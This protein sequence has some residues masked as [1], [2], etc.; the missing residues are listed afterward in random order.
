[1]VTKPEKNS[2]AWAISGNKMGTYMG[3]G[4]VTNLAEKVLTLFMDDPKSRRSL[5]L[6]LA[7][8]AVFFLIAVMTVLSLVRL[9]VIH[10]ER[11]RKH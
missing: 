4:G 3:M 1:M 8:L 2:D 7:S 10:E 9:S 6:S 11:P 5:V